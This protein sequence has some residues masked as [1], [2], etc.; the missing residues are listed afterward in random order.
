MMTASA[1]SFMW[2]SELQ[3]EPRR[4]YAYRASNAHLSRV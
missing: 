4:L 1:A 2:V 3:L